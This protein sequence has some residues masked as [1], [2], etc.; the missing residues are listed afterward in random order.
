M[1]KLKLCINTQTPLVRFKIGYEE[2]LEKYGEL[3]YP[4]DVSE[5]SK[6]EDYYLSPGGVTA[7]VLAIVKSFIS[8]G[9][10]EDV[11][12]VSLNPNAPPEVLF[13][14][15]HIYNVQLPSHYV[16]SYT[17]FKEGIW[18]EIH[19]VGKL[20]ITVQEYEAYV[21]YNWLCA[22]KMLELLPS[23]DLFWIHDFQQ[24]QVGSMI[25]PSAPTIF[26]WHIPFNVHDISSK[27]RNFILKNMESHDAVIVS[28]RRDLE[29][30]IRAGFHGRAFQIYPY[31]DPHRWSKVSE[32][33][34]K[35][36]SEKYGIS[37]DDKVALVVA[38]MDMIKG[39]DVAI[40]AHAM[41]RREEPRAKLL[42]VGN[43]SFTS[44]GLGHSKGEVWRSKLASLMR[45]L[46][47]EDSVRFLG[48]V[49][50]SDLKCLY[51]RADVVILPS[52]MEGFGLTVVEAWQYKRPVIVSKGA[53]VSELII[54]G[55]NGL[56]H[57]PGSHEE[58]YEKMKIVY[59]NSEQ[60]ERMGEIGYQTAKQCT[61]EAASEK[62]KAVFEEVLS[63]Y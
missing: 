24:L 5:L 59:S 32:E 38:R 63:H 4:I 17:N 15:I 34:V 55:V 37:E 31:I 50:D 1:G 26:R 58:L 48:Y 57:E 36:V 18:R 23:V 43:G 35:R 54:E 27:L 11:K 42:L 56:T 33:D 2:L 25:G 44:S 22:Q 61:I 60:A 41:I 3:K 19:G 49:N 16:R 29:A 9:Y 39:Q 13:E 21:Y 20:D 52:K 10:V 12:W 14:G 7:V 30:L 45:E 28:T 6:D 46:K 53:G 40:R 8:K 62:L 51:A 47:V